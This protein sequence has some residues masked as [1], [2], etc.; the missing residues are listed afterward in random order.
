MD[1]SSSGGCG[2]AGEGWFVF[3]DVTAKKALRYE[4]LPMHVHDFVLSPNC[5]TG[6]PRRSSSDT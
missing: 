4:K 3:Y 5:G 6:V 2:G 1:L